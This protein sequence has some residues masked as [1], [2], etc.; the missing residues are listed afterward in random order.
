MQ[1]TMLCETVTTAWNNNNLIMLVIH[2]SAT[3]KP[4]IVS[5]DL[6]YQ[7]LTGKIKSDCSHMNF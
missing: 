2:F 7:V 3:L 1:L 6:L 5:V 4:H